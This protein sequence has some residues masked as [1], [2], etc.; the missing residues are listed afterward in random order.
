MSSGV[1]I[2]DASE[3]DSPAI[4]AI[5]SK[6]MRA[7]Y[8]GL[9]DPTAVDAA[10]KQTYAY[11]AI[12]ECIARCRSA[13][14]A[15]FVVAELN[16]RVI[17]YLHFDCFGPEPELHRIYLD[18]SERGSGVGGV[19]MDALHDRIGPDAEYMLLV[20]EGNDRAVRFYERH[21]LS[22]AELVDGLAYYGERMGVQFPA[23]TRSFRLV[24]M[25][26]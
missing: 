10:V 8:A 17:G 24:L 14:D 23:G 20:A 19:L 21:G 9:V 15:V 11:S 6:A 18:E 22:I 2:R 5:G 26:R 3:T 12:A 16:G 13:A 4:S 7:Q 1:I 25:R